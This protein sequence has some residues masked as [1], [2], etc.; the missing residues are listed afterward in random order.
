M[1]RTNKYQWT[2]E[3]KEPAVHPVKVSRCVITLSKYMPLIYN[4]KGASPHPR[5]ARSRSLQEHLVIMPRIT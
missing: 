1:Y 5:K 2:F 3:T 4:F